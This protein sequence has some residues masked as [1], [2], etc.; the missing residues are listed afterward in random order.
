MISAVFENAAKALV[1][2]MTREQQ[3]R[4]RARRVAAQATLAFRDLDAS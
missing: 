4:P 1:T 3:I 2:A